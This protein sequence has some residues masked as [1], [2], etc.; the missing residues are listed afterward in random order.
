MPCIATEINDYQA[1][2]SSLQLQTMCVRTSQYHTAAAAAAAAGG[3]AAA[4]NL[5]IKPYTGST[6]YTVDEASGLI[7]RHTET[8]DISA[9]DAFVSTLF[10]GL[11]Y[12]APPA[13]PV[14]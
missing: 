2:Y 10:P 14:K 5:P 4:G 1:P 13:P 12:G 6:V 8:W 7:T 3:D 11:K 9:V